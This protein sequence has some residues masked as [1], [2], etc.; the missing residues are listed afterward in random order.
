MTSFYNE[1][2]GFTRWG[3]HVPFDSIDTHVKEV[4]D[5]QDALRIS[6]KLHSALSNTQ[7]TLDF[8]EIV[9]FVHFVSNLLGGLNGA[10][11]TRLEIS[12]FAHK[13]F[14]PLNDRTR[15]EVKTNLASTRAVPNSLKRSWLHWKSTV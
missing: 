1:D 12:R 10:Q 6:T 2:E 13:R 8:I 14:L 3:V 4:T 7:L 11:S 5:L 9:V 15:L